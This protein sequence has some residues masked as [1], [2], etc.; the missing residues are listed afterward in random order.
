AVYASLDEL[1]AADEEDLQHIDGI[2]PEV[3]A[4]IVVWF[5]ETRNQS[6]LQRLFSGGVELT[7]PAA[8]SGGAFEGQ[9]VVFTGTLEA[10][11]RAE[12]KQSVEEQGGRVASSVSSRTDFL[13]QGG[14]PGSKARKASEAGVRVLLEEEFLARVRG[15]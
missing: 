13:V 6:F 11:G 8:A 3:A 1:Q 15:K 12:A 9:T 10:M 7:F 2:G 4:K 14:K 5:G